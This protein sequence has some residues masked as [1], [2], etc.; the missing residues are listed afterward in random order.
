[1]NPQAN[2]PKKPGRLASYRWPMIVVGLLV[3]HVGAMAL[4]VNIAGRD[5][6]NSVLPDYY[7]RALAWDDMRAKAADSA[8]LGWE[9]FVNTSPFLEENGRRNL[10]VEILDK[11]KNPVHGA[12]VSV[13][14]W[15]RAQGKAVDGMLAEVGETGVYQGMVPMTQPGLWN[16]DLAAELGDLLH[17]SAREL[18]VVNADE[19]IDAGLKND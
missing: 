1:M 8:L 11:L 9:V 3:G 6:G 12:K 13:R 2:T 4:A 18:R 10:R 16:C 14:F 7:A 17:V 19:L 5:N 15:H